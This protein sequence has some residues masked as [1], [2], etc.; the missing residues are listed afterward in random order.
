MVHALV[1]SPTGSPLSSDL[2][3]YQATT[4]TYSSPH[5]SNLADA[6]P[7]VTSGERAHRAVHLDLSPCTIRA[8]S[9]PTGM[10]FHRAQGPPRHVAHRDE[11]LQT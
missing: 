9:G 4:I 5:P 1:I 11:I 10:Q 7:W 2:H 8:A 3:T 6:D